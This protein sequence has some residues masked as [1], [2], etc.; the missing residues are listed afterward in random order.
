VKQAY[1]QSQ[2]VTRT[3]GSLSESTRSKP[4]FQSTCILDKLK[5]EAML[6][7]TCSRYY[8]RRIPRPHVQ[9][10]TEVD[11]IHFET[12]KTC[13]QKENLENAQRDP[14]KRQKVAKFSVLH[15]V[16]LRLVLMHP[17]F[18]VQGIRSMLC[19]SAMFPLF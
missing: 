4:T 12:C 15:R 11:A 10:K 5:L 14:T 1:I 6:K 7:S 13:H 17:N 3:A 2:N 9:A 8:P 19:F 16:R 18:Y